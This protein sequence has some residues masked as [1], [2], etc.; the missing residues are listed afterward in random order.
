MCTSRVIPWE[1]C[2]FTLLS[3]IFVN[4]AS[5]AEVVQGTN[6]REEENSSIAVVY[7]PCYYRF[8]EVFRALLLLN[9]ILQHGFCQVNHMGFT[10]SCKRFVSVLFQHCA[11]RR[12]FPMV[13]M[14]WCDV[15]V[16]LNERRSVACWCFCTGML[17]CRTPG[18]SYQAGSDG[19]ETIAYRWHTPL[20]CHHP[21][22]DKDQRGRQ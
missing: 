5:F 13:K 6:S 15:I 8:M 12:Y 1:T 7:F 11:H 10:D 16:E 2:L 22:T 9:Y 3:Y 20:W 18:Q 21:G 14:S 17:F 19:G 4:T